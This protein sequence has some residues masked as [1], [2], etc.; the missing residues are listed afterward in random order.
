MRSENIVD[1][2]GGGKRLAKCL[3][4]PL[5]LVLIDLDYFKSVNDTYGHAAG[6]EVLKTVSAIFIQSARESDIV[7]RYGGEEFLIALPRM[8]P[9]QALLRVQEWRIELAQTDIH[10][11][12]AILKVTLSAGIAVYPM[13][14]ADTDTLVARA[15]EALYRSKD[16]GRNC[17]V[18]CDV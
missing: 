3:S 17:V 9:A 18:C 12:D 11:G 5:A 6:D 8:S 10:V 4:Y 13:H 16:L 7:C 15:D 2:Y 14:G 1:L